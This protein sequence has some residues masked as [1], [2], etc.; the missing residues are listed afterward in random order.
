MRRRDHTNFSGHVLISS[1]MMRWNCSKIFILAVT[2]VLA[3]ELHFPILPNFH[4]DATSFHVL[5]HL[6]T[7]NGPCA[8]GYHIGGFEGRGGCITRGMRVTT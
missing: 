8:T 5:M 7:G 6:E 1:N 2:A 3:S 4:V